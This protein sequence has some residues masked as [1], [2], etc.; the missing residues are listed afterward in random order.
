MTW[1]LF[2]G[3]CLLL[4]L[5]GAAVSANKPTPFRRSLQTDDTTDDGPPPFAVPVPTLATVTTPTVAAPTAVVG[6]PTAVVGEPTAVVGEPTA[7]VGQPTAQT[8]SAVVETTPTIEVPTAPGAPTEKPNSGV[9]IPTW[10]PCKCLRDLCLF[11]SLTSGDQIFQSSNLLIPP[12]T[13]PHLTS[14]LFCPAQPTPPT[15]Q[16]NP[17]SSPQISRPRSLRFPCSP[18][19]F[20]RL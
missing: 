2:V 8:P 18:L 7:V 15:G 5:T 12:L 3:L 17:V 20:R 6:E 13:S 4:T 19:S 11:H 9:S 16:L 10:A 14:R 1:G